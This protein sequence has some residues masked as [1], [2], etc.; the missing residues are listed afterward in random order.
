MENS[1]PSFV[2]NSLKPQDVYYFLP[3]ARWAPS[4]DDCV[5]NVCTAVAGSNIGNN[6]DST[7]DGKF[8]NLCT[9]GAKCNPANQYHGG[10]GTNGK[11]EQRVPTTFT[12]VWTGLIYGNA[13]E[14][15]TSGGVNHGKITL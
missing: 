15:A 2:V 13:N 8:V 1:S 6:C 11:C 7:F 10:C 14:Y 5:P 4:A 3:H 9:V 12:S